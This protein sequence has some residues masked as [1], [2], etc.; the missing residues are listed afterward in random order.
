MPKPNLEKLEEMPHLTEATAEATRRIEKELA[1]TPEE[2]EAE[3]EAEQEA[4]D[5]KLQESYTFSFEYKNGRGRIT[6]GEFTNRILSHRGRQA[7]GLLQAQWQLGMSNASLD[8]EVSGMNYVLAHMAV[9]LKPGKGADWA[10]NADGDIELRDLT[11]IDLIQALYKEV[12]A[13]EATF[14]GYGD[15]TKESK[16]V[17]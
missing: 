12:S 6:R 5:P 7:V 4:E 1:A 2:K 15:G 9:S 8:S 17:R 10:R 11:D 13:H 3:K 14:H 16:S